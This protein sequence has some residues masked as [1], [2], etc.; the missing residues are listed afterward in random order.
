[1]RGRITCGALVHLTCVLYKYIKGESLT[2]DDESDGHEH[3]ANAGGEL[4]D[5]RL[6]GGGMGEKV[7]WFDGNMP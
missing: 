7:R 6:R 5:A 4:V 2:F 1:M 3:L